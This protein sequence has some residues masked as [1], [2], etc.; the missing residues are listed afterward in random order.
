MARSDVCGTV[1]SINEDAAY[2]LGSMQ[3]PHS[4]W[5]FGGAIIGEAFWPARRLARTAAIQVVR[6]I[7]MPNRQLFLGLA[8]VALQQAIINATGQA[9]NLE[10]MVASLRF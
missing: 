4:F 2:E 7:V 10:P 3:D 6:E 1:I 9:K 8:M 5:T